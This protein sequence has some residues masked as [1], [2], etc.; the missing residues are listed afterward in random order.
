MRYKSS[1]LSRHVRENCFFLCSQRKCSHKSLKR[2]TLA[3][4]ARKLDKKM[5]WILFREEMIS[6]PYPYCQDLKRKHFT[7]KKNKEQL[8][9]LDTQPR[10][11]P[12][13]NRR[14]KC[15]ETFVLREKLFGRRLRP[16]TRHCFLHTSKKFKRLIYMHIATLLW[17]PLLRKLI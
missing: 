14:K 7:S 15:A 3:I 5:N 9:I 4:F 8:K 16:P 1:F 17:V 2:K 12:M 13:N 11:W 6:L 10:S